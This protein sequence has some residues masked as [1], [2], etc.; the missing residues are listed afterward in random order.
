MEESTLSSNLGRIKNAIDDIRDTLEMPEDSIEDIASTVVKP[1]IGTININENGIVDV[2]SY[3]NADI[4]VK[5]NI[6][7]VSSTEEMNALEVEE[8]DICLIHDFGIYPVTQNATFDTIRLY[9]SFTLSSAVSGSKMI[10][11]RRGNQSS[12]YDLEVTLTNSNC[13]IRTMVGLPRININYTKTNGVYTTTSITDDYRDISLGANYSYRSGWDDLIREIIQAPIL[14]FDGLY[15]YKNQQWDYLNIGITPNLYNILDTTTV[16]SNNGIQ[17]GLKP[18]MLCNDKKY[19]EVNELPTIEEAQSQKNNL[20]IVYYLLSSKPITAP[21]YPVLKVTTKPYY[22]DQVK[23]NARPISNVDDIS[24]I[25]TATIC[26]GEYNNNLY[27]YSNNLIWRYN[28]QTYALTSFKE[29]P[30]MSA[31]MFSIINFEGHNYLFILGS[32]A[33][34]S[35]RIDL[36]TG[37]EINITSC[38]TNCGTGGTMF[39]WNYNN[40]TKLAC[41]YDYNYWSIYNYKT[42]TWT[43]QEYIGIYHN[44]TSPQRVYAINRINETEYLALV[45]KGGATEKFYYFRFGNSPTVSSLSRPTNSLT[46]ISSYSNTEH[47]LYY[48]AGVRLLRKVFYE[49]GTWKDEIMG[50]CSYFHYSNPFY[51]SGNTAYGCAFSDNQPYSVENTYVG[52]YDITLPDPWSANGLL[53]GVIDND[54]PVEQFNSVSLYNS[55]SIDNIGQLYQFNIDCGLEGYLGTKQV[56][57]FDGSQFIKLIDYEE[58][59]NS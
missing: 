1:P 59:G 5:T 7:K 9:K 58:G 52:D 6:Y 51:V 12:S 17:V 16:Y 21:A 40:E 19:I 55:Q 45:S 48:L 31:P 15:Q 29:L 34:I 39:Q 27:Y 30:T 42:D 3:I 26:I 41:P 4:N 2:S 11:F 33:D 10:S 25:P 14:I 35:Y 53:I 22:I 13:R 36:D 38:P 47:A 50:P 32:N 28:M 8:G 43:L 37:E 23:F 46:I 24:Y 49:G 57:Y 18:K 44:I 20:G 54:E 56:Y